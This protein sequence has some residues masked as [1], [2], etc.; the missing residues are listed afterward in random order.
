MDSSENLRLPYILSAQAQKHVT[1]NE[2]IRGLDA[3]V[4][5]SVQSAS[6]T[7]PPADPEPGSRYIAAAGSTGDWEGHDGEI[8]AFQDGAWMFYTPGEGWRA[9]NTEIQSLLV[10]SSGVWTAF[11]A[12]EGGGVPVGPVETLPLLGINTTADPVNRLS[13]TSPV[14]LLNAEADSHRL[15]INR[16]SISDAASIIFQTGFGGEAEIGLGGPDGFQIRV[17]NDGHT[18]ATAINVAPDGRVSFPN[19]VD[20]PDQSGTDDGGSGSPPPPP[21]PA[22]PPPPPLP[23][24]GFDATA[25]SSLAGFWPSTP[26]ALSINPDGTGG[27]PVNGGTFGRITDLS[28]NGNHLVAPADVNQHPIYASEGALHKRLTD[29]H[30]SSLEVT[31]PGWGTG[32]HYLTAMRTTDSIGLWISNTSSQYSHY[33]QSGSLLASAGM[34]TP[35]LLLDGATAPSS[36]QGLTDGNIHLIEVVDADLTNW[37]IIREAFYVDSGNVYNV[38]GD[39]F[40]SAILINPTTAELDAVKEE[41]RRLAG[42]G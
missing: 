12:G 6:L 2:A 25:I 32:V 18:F 13:V 30:N 1:H 42:I 11:S 8:A 31:N 21:P 15:I 20:L 16:A 22:P 36:A 23:P 5:L 27:S 33:W 40:A 39:W 17:S 26:D 3:I 37:P 29:G 9:W 7:S 4:Q 41:M 24:T 14:T 35:T 19:G 38:L 34:G 28:G 10:Y